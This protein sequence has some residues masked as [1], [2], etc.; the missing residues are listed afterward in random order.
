[1]WLQ[2]Y[3]KKRFFLTYTCADVSE[4]HGT[5]VG[6]CSV[7]KKKLRVLGSLRYGPFYC[8]RGLMKK[9]EAVHKEVFIYESIMPAL[10]STVLT[11]DYTTHCVSH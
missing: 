8:D 10:Q 1:M 11:T 7:Y 2:R 4:V 3:K 6:V 5:T 9:Y